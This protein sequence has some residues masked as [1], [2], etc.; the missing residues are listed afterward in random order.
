MENTQIKMKKHLLNK[1]IHEIENWLKLN[2][3][4][5]Y[6]PTMDE[7]D[8]LNKQNVKHKKETLDLLKE[9]NQS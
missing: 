4:Q 7:E 6:L 5:M 2:E 8:L 3:D 9:L 1:K